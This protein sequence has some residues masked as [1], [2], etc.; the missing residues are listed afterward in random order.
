MGTDHKQIVVHE[1]GKGNLD[2]IK[3]YV[4]EGFIGP[5]SFLPE[6]TSLSNKVGVHTNNAMVDMLIGLGSK[7]NNAFLSNLFKYGPEAV[8]KHV[9]SQ[10]YVDKAEN[11]V[12]LKKS[13]M[14]YATSANDMDAFFAVKNIINAKDV[15]GNGTGNTLL[16]LQAQSGL[17]QPDQ[18]DVPTLKPEQVTSITDTII[19]TTGNKV[20]DVNKFK[21]TALMY[22]AMENNEDRK[23]VV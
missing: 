9:I 21:Q 2:L 8:A 18:P 13:A 17:G 19:S 11:A 7:M 16:M 14:T 5:D 1:I 15:D 20:N 12:Q 10:G 23:S 6:L 4:D 22:A 3:Q